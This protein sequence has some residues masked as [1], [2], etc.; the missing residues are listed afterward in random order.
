MTPGIASIGCLLGIVFLFRLDRDRTVKTSRA[1]WLPVL[2]LWIAGSRSVG[3]WLEMFGIGG[4]GS[5]MDSASQ[6]LEG[7]PL[8][9]NV[10]LALTLIGV[11]ILVNRRTQVARLLRS[12]APVLIFFLYCAVSTLWSDYTDV[13]FKRWI[14]A[15]G[16]LVMVL[17]ILSDPEPLAAIK[18][19]L[20]RVGFVL[21]PLSVLFIKY[22]PAWGR[23]YSHFDGRGSNIGVTTTKNILGMVCLIF[24]IGPLWRLWSA[25]KD[26]EFRKRGQLLAQGVLLATTF[27]LFSMADSATSFSCYLMVVGLFVISLLGRFGRKPLTVN[28]FVLTTIG[29]AIFA[30]FGGAFLG[31]VGRD[32]TLTGRTDIWKLVLSLKGNSLVGTGF[33]SFWLGWRREKLWST[34]RFHLNESHNGYIE[35][36]INLGWIGIAL[37][38]VLLIT[39][40][41]NSMAAYRR[42]PEAGILR[43]AYILVAVIYNFTEAGF[44]MLD[45]VW[46]FFLLAVM[47]WPEYSFQRQP[48]PVSVYVEEPAELAL[49][50]IAY[51][52]T[53]ALRKEAF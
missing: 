7:S 15:L 51:E 19:V 53:H 29:V 46:V 52:P 28:L 13:S 41:R 16:D 21:L 40:Y 43:L 25:V 39:G 24:G 31:T 1:L 12:N 6:Y 37:L 44:R 23:E 10:F 4:F 5:R 33:E 20:A 50:E 14:K 27:W 45:P 48:Q 17:I 11:G 3:Q 26:E 38:A 9:R 42:N 30:I 22:F 35:T 18:R 8:D 47:A 34:Y 36:Y 49:R 32:A 2:W